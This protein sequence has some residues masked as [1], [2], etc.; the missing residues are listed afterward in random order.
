MEEGGGDADR[1]FA[2]SEHGGGGG[3]DPGDQ[4]RLGV[5]PKVEGAGPAP[6]LGFVRPDL[7]RAAD[8]HGKAQEHSQADRKQ[9]RM[10]R[11]ALPEIVQC[12]HAITES[13]GATQRP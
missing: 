6:V 7:E 8:Q 2:L 5:V 1:P 13:L 4:R 3:D 9:D 12:L 11:V 10:R